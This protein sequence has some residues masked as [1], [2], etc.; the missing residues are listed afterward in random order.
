MS[1]CYDCFMSSRTLMSSMSSS[2]APSMGIPRRTTSAGNSRGWT[3]DEWSRNTRKLNAAT[4]SALS[5]EAEHHQKAR[6]EWQV[7]GVLRQAAVE[8]GSNGSFDPSLSNV[9]HA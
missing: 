8:Q 5:D 9:F 7:T 2:Q 1:S 3:R 6:S 4:S